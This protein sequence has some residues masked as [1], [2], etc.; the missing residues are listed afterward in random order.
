MLKK[1]VSEVRDGLT[2]DTWWVHGDAG[3]NKEATI[4]LKA[5]FGG[6]QVF[7]TPKPVKL[8][9]RL[10]RLC[11]GKGDPVLDFFAGS[12][13]TGHAVLEANA[14]DGGTRPFV[15][16]QLPEATGRKDYRTIADIT[17]ERVRRA[18]SKV[19][20]EAG[21]T[22]PQDLGFRVFKLDS[23]NVKP[24]DPS[25][26]DLQTELR[27]HIDHIKPGR[28]EEDLLYEALLKLGLDLSVGIESRVIE[29]LAVYN[30]GAGQLMACLG[31]PITRALATPLARGIIEWHRAT[32]PD[33]TPDS[34]SSATLLFRDAAFVD[35]VA[36]QNLVHTLKQAGFN[37]I[38]SL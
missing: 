17:K 8:L 26:E 24:W 19:R 27:E 14:D 22:A 4:Q 20:E 11:C 34:A 16:V 23:T 5:L 1:F 31:A 7:D 35:D 9:R 36:K 10:I 18:A 28:S 32:R 30:I 33:S 37:T 38:R 6:E 21:L 3:S 2:P 13:V 15:L 29:G 25:P 12:G